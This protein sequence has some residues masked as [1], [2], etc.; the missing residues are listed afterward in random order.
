MNMEGISRTEK[1]EISMHCL[2]CQATVQFKTCPP[3][4]TLNRAFRQCGLNSKGLSMGLYGFHFLDIKVL[5]VQF[6]SY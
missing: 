4:Y 2:G 1:Q 5:L 6:L 3:D